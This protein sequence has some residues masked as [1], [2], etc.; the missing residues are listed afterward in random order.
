MAAIVWAF[1]YRKSS[2]IQAV[3]AGLILYP[4]FATTIPPQQIPP[5]PKVISLLSYNVLGTNSDK[6][7]VLDLLTSM[8]S[9]ITLLIEYSGQ[10]HQVSQ[11]LRDSNLYAHEAPR[12]H[13]F[14]IGMFSRYPLENKKIELLTKDVTDNPMLLAEVVIGDQRLIVAA[15]HFLAPMS[16]ERMKIR[17]QQIADTVKIIERY[18]NG[19]ELPVI[20]VGDM[21]AVA[22][23]TYI[24]Q[25]MQQTNLRDS[26]QGY[27]Y[28]G[29]WPTDNLLLR[30]P[31]DNALV[32]PN[33]HIHQRTILDDNHSDH[34]PL[35]LE[36]SL[37]DSDD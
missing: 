9:D 8:E 14:G 4:V 3:V 27:F 22:W 2:F 37:S 11:P 7:P 19:R 26:R 34:L 25:L 18:Q 12:W 1:G 16:L 29:S 5:G 33:V 28:H 10:W 20:L 32:S 15:V 31:I 21:N 6:E 13:G 24:E 36:F 35:L 23:S 30:I 17:N